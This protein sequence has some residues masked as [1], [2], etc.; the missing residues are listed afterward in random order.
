MKKN[1]PGILEIFQ[2]LVTASLVVTHTATSVPMECARNG[3]KK[4]IGLNNLMVFTCPASVETSTPAGSGIKDPLIIRISLFKRPP[5]IRP[6]I[7]ARK[8][9]RYV[10]M[11]VFE[12]K[13]IQL[14]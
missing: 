7:M 3:A 14:F 5:I 10:I 1:M 9:L 13:V 2:L 8:F 12:V 4:F 11:Y 6:A